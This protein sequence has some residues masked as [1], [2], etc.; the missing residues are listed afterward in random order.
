MRTT[1]ILAATMML[2]AAPAFCQN[3]GATGTAAAPSPAKPATSAPS[4]PAHTAKTAVTSTA[5]SRSAAALALSHE[6]TFDEGTAQQ[7]AE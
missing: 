1:T 4:A 5:K 3:T 7:F 2:A 6:P